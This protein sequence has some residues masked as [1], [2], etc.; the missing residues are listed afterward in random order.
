M[1]ILTQLFEFLRNCC[2]PDERKKMQK[3]L[4]TSEIYIRPEPI[5]TPDEIQIRL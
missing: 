4:K 5:E 3:V 2:F 1:N